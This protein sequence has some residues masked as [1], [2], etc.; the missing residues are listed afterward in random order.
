[1]PT[2]YDWPITYIHQSQPM[3][4]WAASAAMITGRTE[5]DILEEFADFGSDGAQEPE[6]QALAQRLPLNIMPLLMGVTSVIQMRLTPQPT[7]DNMQAKMFKFMPYMFIVFCYNYSCAL[8]IYWTVGN[9]FTIGQ[10]LII[11]RMSDTAATA[12]PAEAMRGG[13]SVKNVTPSKKKG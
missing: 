6:C 7:T 8:A 3:S 9:I 1:M 5:A 11:N 10:Q 13:R 4:C 2:Q 12:V